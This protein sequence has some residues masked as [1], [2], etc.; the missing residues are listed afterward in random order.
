[1]ERRE[2][3]ATYPNYAA[4]YARLS[5]KTST[6]TLDP[7]KPLY[8]GRTNLIKLAFC[9]IKCKHVLS[10]QSEKLSTRLSKGIT[11]PQDLHSLHLRALQFQQPV[12]PSLVKPAPRMHAAASLLNVKLIIHLPMSET[13]NNKR[14]RFT[15]IRNTNKRKAPN[16]QLEFLTE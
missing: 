13:A 4:D 11:V 14:N 1:M 3:A 2:H 7:S 9:P 10:K 8:T 6:Q 16:V 5:Y 12:C 15:S